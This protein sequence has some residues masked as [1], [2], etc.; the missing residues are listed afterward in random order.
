MSKQ[1]LLRLIKRWRRYEDRGDWEPI[2]HKARGLYVL[3]KEGPANRDSKDKTRVM[4][5]AYIGIAGIGKRLTTG[6]GARLRNHDK[7]K[8]DWTHY[9]FFEVHD[10]VTREDIRELESLLLV[11]FRHDPRI[12]LANKYRG[13]SKLHRLRDGDQFKDLA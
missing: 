5:V 9:S 8:K 13:S 11:I 3:Y 2:P 1:S 12:E 10:N 4:Q 6:I 7:S